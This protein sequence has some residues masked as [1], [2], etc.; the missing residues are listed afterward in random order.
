[1]D[2]A[3]VIPELLLGQLGTRFLIDSHALAQA[4]KLQLSNDCWLRLFSL[5]CTFL[6]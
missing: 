3:P 1:M 6:H 4:A 5:T 2:T